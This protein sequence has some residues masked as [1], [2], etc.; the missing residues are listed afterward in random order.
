M[1]NVLINS[2]HHFVL[3][4][5]ILII[6]FYPSKYLCE[7]GTLIV[8]YQTDNEG[9]RLN[10]I[11]F[12]IK[13]D[14]QLQQQMYPKADGYVED[15]DLSPPLRM[16][17]IE[18]LSPGTYVIEFVIPNADGRFEGILPRRFSIDHPDAIVKIDQVIGIRLQTTDL[19]QN[20]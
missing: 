7:A 6:L 17:V 12:W 16:V 11:R 13:N 4:I 9:E 2:L 8:T 14:K 18:D 19:F 1:R 20:L 3:S 15:S 10:R 5:F